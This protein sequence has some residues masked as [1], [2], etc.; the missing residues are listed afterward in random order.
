M[1]IGEVIFDFPKNTLFAQPDKQPRQKAI[2]LQLVYPEMEGRTAANR[3]EMDKIFQDSRL[4]RLLIQDHSWLPRPLSGRQ[5]VNNV[6]SVGVTGRRGKAEISQSVDT[7]TGLD[8]F[9]VLASSMTEN[10][11]IL[12]DPKE[13][14]RERS[15]VIQCNR[16]R[17]LPQG[18]LSNP[19]CALH[20]SFRDLSV[21]ASFVRRL[22]PQWDA[23]R[24]RV[25]E[26]M[27][28]S[29]AKN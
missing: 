25:T 27:E 18:R 23:I 6:F 10:Y 9:H 1:T 29:V 3:A 21:Q 7:D 15:F 20:F 14:E 5:Y 24:R 22:L 17:P 19:G 12:V 13:T 2:L 8:D 4:V 26:W 16:Q 28:S 11:D